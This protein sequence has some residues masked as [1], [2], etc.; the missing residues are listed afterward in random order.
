MLSWLTTIPGAAQDQLNITQTQAEAVIEP[1]GM[2]DDLGRKAE[3]T[4][5]V[6][7]YRHTGQGATIPREPPT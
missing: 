1:H 6:R 4:I 7:R 3:A 5:W 2:L